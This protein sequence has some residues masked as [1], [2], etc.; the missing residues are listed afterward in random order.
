[1][2]NREKFRMSIA[3]RQRRHF[4]VNFKKA[5]I[6]EIEAGISRI[7]DICK[8][9]EVSTTSVYKW[10]EKYG[11]MQDKPEKLI[12]EDQSDT[13]ELLMLR[14]KIAELEQVIGQKQVLLDFKDKMIGLA[15]AH[16]KV[17]I[18]KKFST[19]QSSTTGKTVKK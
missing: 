16:Y 19:R 5:K 10:I 12:I 9:Y 4:S 7:S 2:A 14:K 15:E 8:E 1:M 3:Q 18:K 17:D 11:T 6:R 13:K